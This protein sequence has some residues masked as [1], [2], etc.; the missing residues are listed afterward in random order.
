MLGSREVRKT[1]INSVRIVNADIALVL[2]AGVCGIRI[3]GGVMTVVSLVGLMISL[4]VG[5]IVYGRI[6]ARAQGK[7]NPPNNKILKGCSLNYVVVVVVLSVPL[8]LFDYLAKLASFSPESF[9]L[10]K[11]GVNALVHMVTIYVLPI[12]FLKNENLIAILAGIAYLFRNFTESLSIVFLVAAMFLLNIAVS[13]NMVKAWSPELNI[14]SLAPVM[15]LVNVVATYL[16]FLI[17][18]AAT[19]VL[20]RPKPEVA[21]NGA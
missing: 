16:V 21:G 12:V 13:L 4:L 9:I 7:R 2:L 3:F 10:A 20:L 14:L 8:L 1:I 19:V 11:E 5:I 6:A 17:F 15:V 18:A